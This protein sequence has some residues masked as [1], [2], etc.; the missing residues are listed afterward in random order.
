MYYQSI[1]QS[2]NH[3]TSK[4]PVKTLQNG[5]DCETN[6]ISRAKNTRYSKYTNTNEN[7]NTNTNIQI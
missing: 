2:I 7:T 4:G 3:K 1:N 6:Y 5:A